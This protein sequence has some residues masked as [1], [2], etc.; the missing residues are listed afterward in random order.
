MEKLNYSRQDVASA[1]GVSLSIVDDAIREGHLESYLIGRKRFVRC[2]AV[3]KWLDYLQGQSNKGKPVI[4]R[5][6]P[7]RKGV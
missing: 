5:P 1:A 3:S 6:S 7:V 4:Y 2:A